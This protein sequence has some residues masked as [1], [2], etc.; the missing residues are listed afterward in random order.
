MG[1]RK[2][3]IFFFHGMGVNV[4]ENGEP[5][6]D[7]GTLAADLLKKQYQ[8]YP[9][10]LIVDFDNLFKPVYINY[11]KIFHKILSNWEQNFS[12]IN[13][14]GIEAS[15]IAI[16]MLE[17]I[18]GG[19]ELDDNFLWT[20]LGDVVFY[21]FFNHVRQL[22]KIEVANQMHQELFPNE[23]GYITSWSII[24]YSLGTIVAHDVVHAM[25]ITSENEAG[26]PILNNIAPPANAIIMIANVSKTLENDSF[27]YESQVIPQL[28]CSKYLNINNKYDPFVT[29]DLLIPEIFDPLGG[30]YDLWDEA[31]QRGTYIDIR[32]TNINEVNTHSFRNY[33]INPS[34]HIPILN[35]ICGIGAIPYDIAENAISNFTGSP[36]EVIQQ[37]YDELVD[38]LS[39]LSWFDGIAKILPSLEADDE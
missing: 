34:V 28:T 5:K 18:E 23:D 7:W 39:G 9:N 6:D 24:A 29:E 35:S 16:R 12:T 11:D 33:I 25:D 38:S 4:D 32:S 36:S 15:E 13:E 3:V 19:T 20:H 17:W 26:I 31:Y 8:S 30:Y 22:V 1:V 10:S 14:A 27:V 2:H 37:K 21:R